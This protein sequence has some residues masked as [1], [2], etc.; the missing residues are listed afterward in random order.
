MLDGVNDMMDL[1]FR[2]IQREDLMLTFD[3]PLDTAVLTELHNL[4]GVT[5]VEPFRSVAARLHFNQLSEEVAIQGLDPDA[6]LRRLIAGNGRPFPLPANGLVLSAI[7]AERL[8]V[9]VGDRI[10]VDVLEGRRVSANVLVAGVVEDYMGMSATLSLPSLHALVQG[11]EVVSGAF[12]EVEEVTMDALNRYL[13][14]LP[15]IAGVAS[16]ESMLVSFE[17]QLNDSLYIVTTLLIAFASVIAV[18]VIYNGARISL[19]ERGH[20]LASL[21]VMGFRRREAAVLLLGEQAIVTALAIP[22]GWFIGYW[23]AFAI[24]QSLESEAYRLP[25]VVGSKSYLWSGLTTAAAAV[26]SGLLI[27]HRINRLD[28]IEVLK[29]RE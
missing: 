25:F 4:E 3:E 8:G 23:L 13:K 2:V 18:G 5:R 24:S 11:P 14:R 27:R 12:L 22:L 28:L 1:Q 19:S 21:R 15:A 6:R 17:K 9:G 29:T 7:L 16:P 20:E 26:F 10:A